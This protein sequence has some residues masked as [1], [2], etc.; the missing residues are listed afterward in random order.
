LLVD[1]RLAAGWSPC[2][3]A[4][5]AGVPERTVR[6]GLDARSHGVNHLWT[7]RVAE[8][9]IASADWPTVGHVPALGATRRVQALTAIGWTVADL[10]AARGVP[11]MTLSVIRGGKVRQVH[12]PTHRAIR[13]MYD[14]LSMT[15]GP[16]AIARKLGADRGYVPP[17]GWA[18]DAA[19]DD[20]DAGPASVPVEPDVDEQ[21]PDAVVVA[22][23]LAGHPCTTT[24]ADREAVVPELAALGKSDPEIARLTGVTPRTVQ[25]DRRRLGVESRWSA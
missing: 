9:L 11:A 4:S 24:V 8:A 18:D 19:L 2:A 14:E 17:L 6:G 20:P 5:A 22:R 13:E 1:E 21:L 23:I 10:A 3:I 15:P 25:R 16:S 12:A 7:R